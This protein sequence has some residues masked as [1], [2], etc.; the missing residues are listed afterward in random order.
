MVSTLFRQPPNHR[1]Q[2]LLYQELSRH[3]MAISPW[4]M[5]AFVGRMTSHMENKSWS[6]AGWWFQPTPLKNHGVSQLGWWHSQYMATGSDVFIGAYI[7]LLHKRM[8]LVLPAFR[9]KKNSSQ[10]RRTCCLVNVNHGIPWL[11]SSH[12]GILDANP[13]QRILGGCNCHGTRQRSEKQQN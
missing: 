10:G 1:K 2:G 12:F 5:L 9:P 8:Q 4:K 11:Q 7:V 3:A 6:I 13:N